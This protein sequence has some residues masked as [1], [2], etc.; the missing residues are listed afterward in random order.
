MPKRRQTWAQF[1]PP[2]GWAADQEAAADLGLTIAWLF[3]EGGGAVA[4]NSADAAHFSPVALT[5]HQ[6]LDLTGPGAGGNLAGP[7][8]RD[9]GT[10][11]NEGMNVPAFT[12]AAFSWLMR[13][14]SDQAPGTISTKQPMTNGTPTVANGDTYGFSWSH[15]NASFKQAA[16]IQDS[17]NT[18]HAAQIG[19]TITVNKFYD[20]CSTWDGATLT[21]YLNGVL[22]ATA[23]SSSISASPSGNMFLGNASLNTGNKFWFDFFV[24]SNTTPWTFQQVIQLY[25]QPFW[26]MQPPNSST[27]FLPVSDSSELIHSRQMLSLP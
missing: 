4:F 23:A 14:A 13:L 7:A 26:W 24:Y 20:I 1:K 9:D 2:I 19:A 15:G 8:M 25:E 11:A 22:Q 16:Y 12:P 27:F 17:T 5:T 3:N 10:T 18:Y 21:C 6:I